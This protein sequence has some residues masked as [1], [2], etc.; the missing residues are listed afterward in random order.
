M[1][2]DFGLYQRDV[3]KRCGVY[4]IEHIATMRVYIGSTAMS[5]RERWRRHITAFDTGLS[6]NVR[7][8]RVYKKYGQVA[9]RFRI[10]AVTRP[11][12]ALLYEQLFLDALKPTEPGKGL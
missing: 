12:D 2:S 8:A 4:A 7:M 3:L 11:E 1:L 5:F 10:L 6:S 9:F